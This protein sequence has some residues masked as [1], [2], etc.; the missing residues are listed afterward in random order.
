MRSPSLAEAIAA[1]EPLQNEVVSPVGS[2]QMGCE[3]L[4]PRARSSFTK[5]SNVWPR[6][7]CFTKG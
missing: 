1:L 2:D 7:K 4:P 6:R 5:G 3:L